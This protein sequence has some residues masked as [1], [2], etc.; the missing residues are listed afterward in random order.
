MGLTLQ[1]HKFFF[2]DFLGFLKNINGDGH[3]KTRKTPPRLLEIVQASLRAEN[4]TLLMMIKNL[5][6]IPRA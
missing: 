5:V 6:K 1:S 4:S 2:F 3:V